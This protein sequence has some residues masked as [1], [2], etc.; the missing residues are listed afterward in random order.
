M[1]HYM[2]TDGHAHGGGTPPKLL[3]A[4]LACYWGQRS[5]QYVM[6]CDMRLTLL[7]CI[8]VTA[9]NEEDWVSA[10]RWLGI[11]NAINHAGFEPLRCMVFC[12]V[13]AYDALLA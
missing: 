9:P 13:H 5:L 1:I 10:A 8:V 11:P 4:I 7:A 3:R 6:D 12:A 2:C